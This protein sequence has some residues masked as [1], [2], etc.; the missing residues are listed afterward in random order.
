M[1]VMLPILTT[2][3]RQTLLLTRLY[4]TPMLPKSHLLITVAKHLSRRLLIILTLWM[5]HLLI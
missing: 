4:L 2:W 1:P 3:K 5:R